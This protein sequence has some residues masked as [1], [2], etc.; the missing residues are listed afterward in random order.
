MD[1]LSRLLAEKGELEAKL[2]ENAANIA[3]MSGA[4]I[5][6]NMV[7][8]ASEACK[9]IPPNSWLVNGLIQSVGFGAIGAPPFTGKSFLASHIA[10]SICSGRHLFGPFTPNK[11][12]PVL[13]LYYESGRSEFLTTI[14]KTLESRGIDGK[15]LFVN[16]ADVPN[17]R[18]RIGSAGFEA[19]I[20]AS[21]ARFVICDTLAFAA[22]VKEESNEEFQN[23]VVGP[24]VDLTKRL[25]IYVL[26]VH[27]PQK[28]TE[29]V[30]DVYA[31]RG[32]STL[33]AGA[34]G[35]FIVRR[36]RGESQESS[37]RSLRI[38]KVRGAHS[39]QLDIEFDFPRRV[40]YCDE[41]DARR[42]L[43]TPDRYEKFKAT[44]WEGEA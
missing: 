19:A 34:D 13:Y 14:K 12:V 29:G 4:S 7:L 28:N 35:L 25:G 41:D 21:G 37:K 8:P 40:A 2:A 11:A 22:N 6:Q 3:E 5:G 27:H 18:L 16:A 39:G 36:I 1:I 23:K 10:G 30:D 26:Y 33:S 32:G 9:N 44:H 42:V 24:T 43:W 17:D 20:R 38:V 15:I 31:F